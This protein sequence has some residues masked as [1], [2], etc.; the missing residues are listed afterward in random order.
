MVGAGLSAWAKTKLPSAPQLPITIVASAVGV[1]VGLVDA[2]LQRDLQ[3][4]EAFFGLWQV[5]GQ[6][7]LLVLTFAFAAMLA[8]LGLVARRS[9]QSFLSPRDADLCWTVG[10]RALGIYAG[11]AAF[12]LVGVGGKILGL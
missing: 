7:Y 11:A 5:I 1:V 12:A 10:E 2:M 8:V 4:G 6:N 9:T 3:P